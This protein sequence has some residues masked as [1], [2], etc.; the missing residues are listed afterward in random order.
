MH[1]D[2]LKEMNSVDLF[3]GIGGFDRA[4]NDIFVPVVYCEKDPYV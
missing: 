3:S 2:K 1:N 4:L